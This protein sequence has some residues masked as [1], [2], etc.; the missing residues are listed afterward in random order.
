MKDLFVLVADADAQAL[1]Q[2]LLG[3][4]QALGI[5]PISY[6]IHR[7]PG[8]D[9]GMVKEG[10][11]IARVLVDKT[12]YSRLLLIWDHHGSGWEPKGAERST[13]L[14]QERLDGVTWL[15]RAS[16]LVLLPELEEWLWHC[17]RSIALHLRMTEG[18]LSAS[19]QRAAS[20]L[21]KPPEQSMRELPKELFE[22]VLHG[23]M[24]RKPLPEDFQTLGASAKIADLRR[25]ASFQSFSRILQEWFAAAD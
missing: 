23:R 24:R 25:S 12:Q 10:P 13:A 7:F 21:G 3:R 5:R 11:E 17:Q 6:H 20:R 16:A 15:H 4:H 1:L 9:S 8:R 18:E 14:I 19:M 2:S 22:I